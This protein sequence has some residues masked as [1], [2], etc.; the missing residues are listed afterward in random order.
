MTPEQV[1][2]LAAWGINRTEKSLG[3]ELVMIAADTQILNQ[4]G[5]GQR[6]CRPYEIDVEDY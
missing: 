3:A 4:I 5:R 1:L 6:P 2:Y